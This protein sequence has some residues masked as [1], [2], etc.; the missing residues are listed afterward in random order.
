MARSRSHAAAQ[1]QVFRLFQL[2]GHPIRVVIFQRLAHAPMTAGE[3]A[4]G[5]S[6]T[7]PGVVQHLKLMQAAGLVAARQ[8]GKRQVYQPDAGGLAPLADWLER[9]LATASETARLHKK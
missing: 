8:A 6:I 3:L 1:R 4:K 5:L 9:Q 2:F 7:R